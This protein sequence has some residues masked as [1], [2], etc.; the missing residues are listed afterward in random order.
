MPLVAQQ[1]VVV[2]RGPY[3]L[4]KDGR[5]EEAAVLKLRA[6]LEIYPPCRIISLTGGGSLHAYTLT[7]VIETV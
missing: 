3:K 1:D 5:V 2:V 4:A 7:A 6:M